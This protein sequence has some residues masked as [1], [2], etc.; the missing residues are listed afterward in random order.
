LYIA[1]AVPGPEAAFRATYSD[2]LGR[3]FAGLH[4]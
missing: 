1:G 3:L 2:S 4:G